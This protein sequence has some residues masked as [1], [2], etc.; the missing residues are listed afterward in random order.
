MAT[1]PSEN[2]FFSA[3]R[4]SPSGP[5]VTRSCATAGRRMYLRRASRPC[6][7]RPPARVAACSV[8]PSSATHNG[9]SN[10]I[11]RC[12]RGSVPRRHSG[13][14]GGVSPET[15]DARAGDG[16]SRQQ[17]A[18]GRGAAVAI[19]RPCA[20][21]YLAR[22]LPT[23]RWP[24]RLSTSSHWTIASGRLDALA[25]ALTS[26]RSALRDPSRRSQGRASGA[27]AESAAR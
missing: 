6:S 20:H 16:T 26:R 11:A 15:A 7:S 14:A 25:A 5:R 3:M 24:P 9:R 22:T 4:T 2:A 19:S 17:Q 10:T 21:H 27:G 12:V 8:N 23:C 18:Q 1:V 13:P